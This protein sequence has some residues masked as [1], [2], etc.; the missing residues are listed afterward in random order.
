MVGDSQPARCQ[1][2]GRGV[3]VP[4]G[5]YASVACDERFRLLRRRFAHLALWVLCGSLG[6]YFAYVALSGFAR[7]F[8]ARTVVGDLNVALLLGLLQ[9]VVT[10]ALTGAYVAY[11][12]RRLDPLAAELR[13]GPPGG[14][15]VPRPVAEVRVP[16]P[17][18]GVVVPE[19]RGEWNKAVRP[20]LGEVG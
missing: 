1:G 10:F 2:I 7:G 4:P 17:A 12:R 20:D 6:W 15:R 14:V 19:P 3:T 5:H 8:M 18:G 13:A 11:A 9:F 16:R